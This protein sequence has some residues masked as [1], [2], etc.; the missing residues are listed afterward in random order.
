M[1]NYF[2]QRNLAID[3][4]RALT[5]FIMVFVN[6]FW[7]LGEIPHW[8]EHA[9]YGEDYMGLADIVFPCFLFA[10]GMSIPYALENRESK[11]YSAGSTLGHI[12]SRTFALLVMGA[13]L[14]NS[15]RGLSD[16]MAYSKGVYWILMFIAF[17]AVWNHYPRTESKSVKRLFAAFK[18]IG[19]VVMLYLAFTFR[20]GEGGVFGFHSSILGLIAWCYLIGALTYFI[21]R[22]RLRYLVPVWGAFVLICLLTSSLR[23]ELG[24]EPV[25]NFPD[26][27]FLNSFLWNIHVGN[28]GLCSLTMGGIVLSVL[29]ARL[30]DYAERRRLMLSFAASAVFL[31]LGIASHQFYIVSKIAATP[32]WIFYIFAISFAAYGVLSWLVKYGYTRWFC[33]FS[34]AGTATLT[35]YIVPYLLYAIELIIGF[36]PYMWFTEGVPGLINCAVFSLITIGVTWL[37]GKAKIKL[38]I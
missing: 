38:K 25:L 37:L 5:V 24:G 7:T 3:M 28:G 9:A 2:L 27:N 6:N 17:I 23:A 18:V 22:D 35:A 32:P 10:V 21:T 34:P 33:V 12:L 26:G 19:W 31:L 15:E 13:F 11:G 36:D 29:C 14:G 4:L 8:L 1:K 20:N 30:R 16:T